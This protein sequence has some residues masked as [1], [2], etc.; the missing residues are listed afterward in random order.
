ML[1]SSD[2]WQ[3]KYSLLVDFIN[4]HSEIVIHKDQ[5]KIP[6]EV[7]ADFYAYFD[8]V[9]KAF[10][11]Q[12]FP[13][14][15]L[16]AA[17]LNR[18]VANQEGIVK[19]LL[20]LESLTYPSILERFLY[21][22]KVSLI[23]EVFDPLFDLVKG[24]ITDEQFELQSSQHIVRSF[25]DLFQKGFEKWVSLTIA[26]LLDSRK[27]Y[28]FD[29]QEVTL[30][31]SHRGSG[32]ITEEVPVPKESKHMMFRDKYDKAFMVPDFI[33]YSPSLKGYVSLRSEIGEALATSIDPSE[34]REWYSLDS[35]NHIWPSRHL[36]GI[37]L[38]YK[39]SQP[40]EISL[41][42]DKKRIYR[43]DMIIECK[44][45]D[46]WWTD[47]KLEEIKIHHDA[48]KPKLGTCIVARKLDGVRVSEK[49][50]LINE[51]N[52]GAPLNILIS[53]FEQETLKPLVTMLKKDT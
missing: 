53:D 45:Y 9:R 37:T 40:E 50:D 16:D 48:L 44:A 51:D 17:K 5:F 15:L 28:Q 20:S 36:P 21:N 18:C 46:D 42:A 31:D 13:A 35:L 24:R 33:V 27:M 6:M 11:E 7:R 47:D 14:L 38:L 1:V 3:N 4:Q 8:D 22:P 26:V 43:P 29:E 10:I 25:V 34:S 49:L 52:T 12:S 32:A 23:R 39:A 41:V 30:Y 2:T 19:N